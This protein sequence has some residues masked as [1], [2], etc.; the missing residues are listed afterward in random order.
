VPDQPEGR[1]GKPDTRSRFKRLS[2]AGREPEFPEVTLDYL[3]NYLIDVGPAAS[4]GMGATPIT[5]LE[6]RAW[7]ENTGIC[8]TPWEA[9]TLRHL[10]REYVS[11]IVAGADATRPAPYMPQ[12]VGTERIAKDLRSAISAMAKK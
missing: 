2:D 10:S 4:G 9:R 1:K 5:H 6:I 12:S 3:A 11:E 7:Q 8:L